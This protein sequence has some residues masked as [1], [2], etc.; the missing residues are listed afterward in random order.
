MQDH[1]TCQNHPLLKDR[2]SWREKGSIL[3]N[4]ARV[5]SQMGLACSSAGNA[6]KNAVSA[7]VIPFPGLLHRLTRPEPL[8]CAPSSDPLSLEDYRNE[9][10]FLDQGKSWWPLWSVNRSPCPHS[11]IPG[12]CS[13]P[14]ILC[15]L[16]LRAAEKLCLVC[17]WEWVGTRI[18]GFW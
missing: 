5:W 12:E 7:Q 10:P 15:F 13:S 18:R 4:P 11:L 6:G 9:I 17:W 1:S 2:T 8:G 16:L 3:I 14:V